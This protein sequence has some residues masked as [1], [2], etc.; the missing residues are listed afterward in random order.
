ML[1]DKVKDAAAEG[2]LLMGSPPLAAAAE[3]IIRSAEE[4]TFTH[5]ERATHAHQVGEHIA[6]VCNVLYKEREE[7]SVQLEFEKTIRVMLLWMKKQY[8]TLYVESLPDAIAGK[9]KMDV[10]GLAG[11]KRD[12]EAI[13]ANAQMRAL[14]ALLQGDVDRA[15][16]LIRRVMLRMARGHVSL[17]D[18]LIA[19]RI[20]N[21]AVS[22]RAA[23]PAHV[24][25]V[26]HLEKQMPGQEP[27][28]GEFV[29]Y[30]LSAGADR[31]RARPPDS[32]FR[33]YVQTAMEAVKLRREK[34]EIN[35]QLFK[36]ERQ[37]QASKAMFSK[38]FTGKPPEKKTI[39]QEA[40][41]DVEA[42]IR[43]H[44]SG[45]AQTLHAR[46]DREEIDMPDLFEYMGR[47]IGCF[48]VVLAFTKYGPALEELYQKCLRIATR[49][50]YADGYAVTEAQKRAADIGNAQMRYAMH[51]MLTAGAGAGA[52]GA[53][54]RLGLAV[55]E[56]LARCGVG[57]VAGAHPSSR[58]NKR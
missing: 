16:L 52:A 48:R 8:G 51:K 36:K 33:E 26:W 41:E 29:K 31:E 57:V 7:K 53:G 5:E 19:K 43:E 40:R 37:Q 45:D 38:F 9:F 58:K 30:W 32:V 39:E 42:R 35:P 14:D 3:H 23:P 34:A 1:I 11:K 28:R 54:L 18:I 15:W 50:M 46:S 10:K 49:V 22:L 13:T 17:E 56:N 47:M 2:R 12:R 24:S 55:N 44:M 4:P 20:D 25:V 6:E 21:K 27:G